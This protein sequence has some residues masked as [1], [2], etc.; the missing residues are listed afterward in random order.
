DLAGGSGRDGRCG[1][2]YV[3]QP[4]Y[5]W[6]VRVARSKVSGVRVG[7]AICSELAITAYPVHENAARG[8][9]PVPPVARYTLA[10][11]EWSTDWKAG[12]SLMPK[13]CCHCWA[14]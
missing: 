12:R 7:P 13:A 11:S 6:L 2:W 4:P 5:D 9:A 8:I 10:P 14:S 1:S 3:C